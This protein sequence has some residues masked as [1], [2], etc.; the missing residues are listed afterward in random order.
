M[1]RGEQRQPCW[2]CTDDGPGCSTVYLDQTETAMLI[3]HRRRARV[4]YDLLGANRDSHVYPP[5]T[6]GQGVLRSTWSKQRQPCWSSTDDGPGCSTVYLEQTETAMLILHRW[7][8]RVC[9]GLLGAN[10]DSHVDPPQTTGQGVL[11]STWS[12]QRQPCWSSTWTDRFYKEVKIPIY[13][14]TYIV[15]FTKF[16]IYGDAYSVKC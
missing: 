1:T 2:S 11:R 12:K 6:T 3:L 10:R 16:C 4:F 5:Q 8:A 7:R 14:W 15:I 13:C 9:Y